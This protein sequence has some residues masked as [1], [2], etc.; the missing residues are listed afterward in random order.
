[1]FQR[2]W[3]RIL[4]VVDFQ[5]Q[6]ILFPAR[7][8]GLPIK[9]LL[10]DAPVNLVHVH[11]ADP[12]LDLVVAGLQPLDRRPT[13]C[14]LIAVRSEDSVLELSSAPTGISDTREQAL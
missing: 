1:M 12:R 4:H 13:S 14:L 6:A 7:G 9:E 5:E 3:C 2:C 8:L 10:R 11:R